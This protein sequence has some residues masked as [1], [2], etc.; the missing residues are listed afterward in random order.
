MKMT[1]SVA[2][3]LFGLASASPTLAD[4]VVKATL[5][6]PVS[7]HLTPVAGTSVFHCEGTTCIANSQND[8]DGDLS[9]CEDLARQV[10]RIT[11]YQEF[12]PLD[13]KRLAKCNNAAPHKRDAKVASH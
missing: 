2:C 13:D 12:K 8:S 5:E 9:A 10:G 11:S 7:G 6:S 4:G 1:L 3:A